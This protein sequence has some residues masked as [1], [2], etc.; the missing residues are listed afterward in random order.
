M[1]NQLLDRLGILIRI[2]SRLEA[3]VPLN[4][5]EQQQIDL[6]DLKRRKDEYVIIQGKI[7]NGNTLTPNDH[8]VL[9]NFITF[10]DND[11]RLS[12]QGSG[13]QRKRQRRSQ[14]KT[15]T[16]TKSKTKTKTKTKSKKK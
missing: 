16:K 4:R 2:I 6:D 10:L 8:E 9:T 1:S 14:R 11:P 5:T 3:I 12:I 13:K 15:K 7:T